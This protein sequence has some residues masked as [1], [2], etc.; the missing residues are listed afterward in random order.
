MSQL[1][2]LPLCN[3]ISNLIAIKATQ[4]KTQHT[5]EQVVQ[6]LKSDEPLKEKFNKLL[7]LFLK[8]PGKPAGAA[9][10]YN[11]SGFSKERLKSLSYDIQKL[12][13]ITSK[14]LTVRLVETMKPV[15]SNAVKG[16]KDL[17]YAKE[18]KPLAIKMAKENGDTLTSMKKADLI[19]YVNQLAEEAANDGASAEGEQLEKEIQ[20]APEDVKGGWKLREEYPFLAEEDCPNELKILTSDMITA[21]NGYHAGREVLKAAVDAGKEEDIFAIASK[22]VDKFE[23]NAEI[24]SELDYYKE[25]KSVLGN[26]P[27]F[28]D[29]VIQRKVDVLKDAELVPRRNNLRTYISKE[30]KK[31][32]KTDASLKKSKEKVADW[33]T[34]MNLIDKRLDNGGK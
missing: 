10:F 19:A 9:R 25:L 26:H 21:Y 16:L 2:Q 12:F 3:F 24:K 7:E 20:A 28:G 23:L 18:L 14:E 31:T 13:G 11:S 27:I 29:L 6:A 5:K 22:I 4:M 32:F 34:E 30:E 17:D 1:L 8:H 15:K 33:K